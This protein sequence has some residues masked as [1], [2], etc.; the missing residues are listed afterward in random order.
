MSQELLKAEEIGTL[1]KPRLPKQKETKTS[2]KKP[3]I[4][5]VVITLT[6]VAAFVATFIGGMNYANGL[7]AER[8]AAV[9]A[10]TSPKA[11]APQNQ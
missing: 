8:E 7:H 2:M 3:I 4:W 10:A 9:K 5:T 6:I 11:Q 1:K